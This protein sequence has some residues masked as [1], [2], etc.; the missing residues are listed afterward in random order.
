MFTMNK[1]TF[2]SVTFYLVAILSGTGIGLASIPL[3][4]MV[5]ALVFGI[6]ALA[7]LTATYLIHSEDNNI[8]I[9]VSNRCKPLICFV[10]TICLGIGIYAMM[11]P[12]APIPEPVI[13]DPNPEM[14][15]NLED[16]ESK[17]ERIRR[18]L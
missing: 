14:E 11:I 12:P 16:C 15:N 5:S 2:Q 9:K 10:M 6:I 8:D 3:N 13:I 7:I 18:A 17:I 1:D 4:F